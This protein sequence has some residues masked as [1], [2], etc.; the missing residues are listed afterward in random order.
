MIE[1]MGVM[2]MVF[3]IC[4]ELVL[5]VV[6]PILRNG[7]GIEEQH[8]ALLQESE[9]LAKLHSRNLILGISPRFHLFDVNQRIRRL[10]EFKIFLRGPRN[11]KI[12]LRS[13]ASC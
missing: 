6:S 7:Y 10:V 13:S 5:R 3:Y 12:F 11:G 1:L 2:L 4:G 8:V 9:M